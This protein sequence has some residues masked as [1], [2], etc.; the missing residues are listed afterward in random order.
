VRTL[1]ST[2]TFFSEVG[3]LAVGMRI[4]GDRIFSP[5]ICKIKNFLFGRVKKNG[6]RV[7]IYLKFL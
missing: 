7:A 6:Y 2:A 3:V 5:K 4:L 1:S